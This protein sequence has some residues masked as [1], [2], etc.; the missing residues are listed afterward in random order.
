MVVPVAPV[1]K[2]PHGP[3]AV[4]QIG[5]REGCPRAGAGSGSLRPGAET[6]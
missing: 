6:R 1:A 4:P 2:Q 3:G 5:A